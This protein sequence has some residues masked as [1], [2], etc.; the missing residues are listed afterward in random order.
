MLA[1]APARRAK[2]TQRETQG[3]TDDSM[4]ALEDALRRFDGKATTILSEARVEFGGRRNFLSELV[5]LAGHDDAQISAGATWLIKN[6]LEDGERLTQ[7]Q[8]A[9]LV[10]R[11]AAIATWPA[12]LHICQSM[13]YL[14]TP[15]HLAG[16]C[17]DWLTPLLQS[18]RPFLRAWSMDALQHL[19]LRS[20]E[21]TGRAAAAL[22]T[23]EQDPAASVR[24][25]ARNWLKQM[26]R[27]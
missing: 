14:K 12:Q 15:P 16:R 20:S 22:E 24:A 27:R 25:R 19:A 21:L 17:A 23:A 2:L 11:L 10:G 9:D 26:T 4:A 1:A 3:W 6:C 13:Q 18:D 5:R 7:R 8:T